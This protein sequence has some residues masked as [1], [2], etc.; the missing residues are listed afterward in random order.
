[1]QQNQQNKNNIVIDAPILNFPNRKF[2]SI[3]KIGQGAQGSVY[4]AKSINWGIN[5]QK[6]YALKC[7][8]ITQ[9]N[10]IQFIDSLIQYQN[11]YENSQQNYKPS[12]LIRIYGRY[13]WNNQD[14]FIMEKG[15]QDLF[16]FIYEQQ[17][18]TFQKKV[19]IL[20]QISQSIQFLHQ[21]ELIHRDIKPE[22]YIK[23]D[24]QFK[25]IDFGL[26]RGDQRIQMTRNIGTCLF[27]APELVEGRQDYSKSVDIWALGCLFYE[28]LTKQPFLQAQTALEVENIIKNIKN[29]DQYIKDRLN[30]LINQLDD[31]KEEIQNLLSK[32]N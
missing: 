7:Q 19:E 11:Q 5:D 31:K 24:N 12:G 32:I 2:E 27:K 22:N 29:N 9:D 15:E 28:L 13:K 18:L 23:I 1:M 14:V 3:N 16:A 25:L 26:I 21:Q 30:Y 4:L 8:G 20:I 17:Q 10:E 6:Q